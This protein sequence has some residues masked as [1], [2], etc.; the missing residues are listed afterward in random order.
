MYNINGISVIL[1]ALQECAAYGNPCAN[2]TVDLAI[3]I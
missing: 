3:G 1:N 2:Q